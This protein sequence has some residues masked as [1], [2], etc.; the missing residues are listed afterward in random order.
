MRAKKG[1]EVIGTLVDVT[2]MDADAGGNLWEGVGNLKIDRQI[3]GIGG[4]GDHAMHPVFM[5]TGDEIGDFL[6]REFVGTEVAVGVGHVRSAFEDVGLVKTKIDSAHRAGLILGV[7]LLSAARTWEGSFAHFSVG[8]S[9][10]IVN[11]HDLVAQLDIGHASG[12]AKKLPHG[13]TEESQL[14]DLSLLLPVLMSQVLGGK[15]GITDV[16]LVVPD[17]FVLPVVF[18][19]FKHGA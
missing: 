3:I 2:G 11:S 13:L 12:L 14:I 1:F 10:A 18:D 16:A 7:A 5:G 8:L 4:Q 15:A 19:E 17:P 9:I 6:A